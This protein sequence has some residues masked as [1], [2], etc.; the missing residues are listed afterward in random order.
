[1]RIDKQ[2]GLMQGITYHC[3]PNQDDRPDPSDISLLVIHGI[4][5]P[6]DDFGNRYVHDLFMNQLDVAHHPYFEAISHLRVS[7]HVFIDRQG[8]ISQYVPF[9]KR[10]WHAGESHFGGRDRCND[11]SVGIELEGT[12]TTPYTEAQYQTLARCLQDLMQT[13]DIP[14]HHIQGHSDIAPNRKSDPGKSFD[15]SKLKTLINKSS[16]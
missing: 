15:W 16:N 3:S 10:A 9:H 8:E 13:Y 4:S 7:S 5:L 14:F 2:S 12:D 6:P 11:F 1:M